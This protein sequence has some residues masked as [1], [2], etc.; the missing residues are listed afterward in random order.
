MKS[1]EFRKLNVELPL[2][3]ITN[4]RPWSIAGWFIACAFFIV[5]AYAFLKYKEVL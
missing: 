1:P 4:D 3:P 2:E 5:V